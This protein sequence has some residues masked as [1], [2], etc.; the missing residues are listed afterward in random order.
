M[1]LTYAD[2]K[3]QFDQ[4]LE[5]VRQDIGRLRRHKPGLNYTVC[6]LIG[7]G[8]EML[9]AGAG[10]KKRRGE[11]VLAEML[12]PGDWRF[13]AERLYTALRDGLAHGFDTKHWEVD[14]QNIQ[15]C[16]SWDN[17]E[18][19]KIQKVRT[20]LGVSIGMKPLSKALRVRINNF[21]QALRTD[22]EA[23][24][25]FKKAYEYQRVTRLNKNEAAAWRRLVAA[26]G[27]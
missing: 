15:L 8:C 5:Y 14:G 21:E 11:K 27:Y 19:I 1:D 16:I 12:P 26:A 25:R 23:R 18:T 17:A 10:D 13:V 7:C 20:G 24:G 2:I 9:A 4:S 3:H 22:E 6:L